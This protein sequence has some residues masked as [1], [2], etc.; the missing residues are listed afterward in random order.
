MKNAIP[1]PNKIMI[2]GI[3]PANTAAVLDDK[4]VTIEVGICIFHIIYLLE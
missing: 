3:L 4:S 1:I 2:K